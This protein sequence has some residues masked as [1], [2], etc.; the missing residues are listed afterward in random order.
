MQRAVG[1]QVDALTTCHDF[2]GNLEFLEVAREGGLCALIAER[3]QLLQQCV[4]TAYALPCDDDA[5]GTEPAM[6]V[7]QCF[8]SGIYIL[9]S[10]S[11]ELDI[12]YDLMKPSI[13]PSIT[14]PTS[15][16]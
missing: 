12:R 4:L 11:D 2:L 7:F 16:V 5:Y 9:Y 15:E 8:L 6:L 1:Q 10:S 14:P 3:Q 13:L